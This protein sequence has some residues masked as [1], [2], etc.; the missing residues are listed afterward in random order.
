MSYYLL[1][2]PNPNGPFYYPTRRCA[3][4]HPY[5]IV[6]HTAEALPDC[7][8]SDT[9]AES[10]ARYGAT[11]TRPVSWHATVDSDSI[12]QMLPPEYTAFHAHGYNSC[13]LG[14]ELATQA[15]AWAQSPQWWIDL[16]I[17]RAAFVCADWVKQYQIPVRRITRRQADEAEGGFISHAA[18]DPG[19]RRDP[20]A[21][22]PWQQFLA[23]VSE[24]VYEEDDV[25][26]ENATW[27]AWFDAGLIQGDRNYYKSGR[28]TQAEVDHAV[29]V[30]FAGLA[31]RPA[32][33]EAVPEHTHTPGA[34]QR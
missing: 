11:T 27:D 20:G 2:H 8:P 14:I 7:D 12:I 32:W 16:I 15:D 31:Q 24:F 33:S 3:F 21:A 18:L 10:V 30:A 34:V 19:R 22:F 9:S 1:D 26:I 5:L 6:V 4:G 17:D 29:N 13:S 25:K 28:A 23:R